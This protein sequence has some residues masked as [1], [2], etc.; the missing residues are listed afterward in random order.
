MRFC[1]ERNR[2][3]AMHWSGFCKPATGLRLAGHRENVMPTRAKRKKANK[4]KPKRGFV[5][6]E[7]EA[8][9]AAAAAR[10]SAARSNLTKA[11]SSH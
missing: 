6:F 11:P 5:S 10:F 4:A 7:K 3:A 1:S 8:W 9:Y 2:V